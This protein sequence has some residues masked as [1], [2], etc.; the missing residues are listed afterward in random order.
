V[1]IIPPIRASQDGIYVGED[2][3]PASVAITDP[4]F[5]WSICGRYQ[6]GAQCDKAR[7]ALRDRGLELDPSS[8]RGVAWSFAKC[9][10]DNDPL[11]RSDRGPLE[12]LSANRQI[13]NRK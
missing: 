13:D 9:L 4:L 3:R 10:K 8:A 1:L 7:E 12:I 2:G 11:L 6:S 5:Q